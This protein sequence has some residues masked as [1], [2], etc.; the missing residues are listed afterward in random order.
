MESLNKLYGTY[1]MI[2]G[3]LH[4]HVRDEFVCKLLDNVA[5]VGKGVSTMV[6]EVL[7]ERTGEDRDNEH[8]MLRIEALSK[9]AFAA[10]QSRKWE[11]AKALYKQLGGKHGDV[12]LD[13]IAEFEVNPPAEEWS[14]VTILSNK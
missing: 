4:E 3:A 9:E 14:G 11:V 7:T 6:Y 5:V 13:R 1:L 2:C 8:E 10:Y 12:F